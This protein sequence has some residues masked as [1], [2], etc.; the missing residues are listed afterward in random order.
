MSLRILFTMTRLSN[1][2][3][4]MIVS[5]RIDCIVKVCKWTARPSV[6]RLASKLSPCLSSCANRHRRIP[7]PEHSHPQLVTYYFCH[8]AF[9]VSVWH[10]LLCAPSIRLGTNVPPVTSIH[11]RIRSRLHSA[12]LSCC[13]SSVPWPLIITIL[14]LNSRS[15]CQLGGISPKFPAIV[16]TT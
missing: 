4:P 3:Q 12:C 1:L 7:V 15:P 13:A 5:M 11:D 8:R 10:F 9:T 2:T 16:Y 14:P 6:N